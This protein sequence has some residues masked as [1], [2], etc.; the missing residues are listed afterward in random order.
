V[1]NL[2][3]NILQAV[4]CAEG[5]TLLFH[6]FL[7]TVSFSP[8]LP[9]P[10]PRRRYPDLTVYTDSFPL[11]STPIYPHFQSQHSNPGL[12]EEIDTLN[13]F[14]LKIFLSPN[15]ISFPNF[16]VPNPEL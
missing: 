11:P 9:P 12:H 14:P 5:T 8:S 15:K 6:S 7:N 10:T 13:V 3:T 16:I 2:F 1:V 4:T